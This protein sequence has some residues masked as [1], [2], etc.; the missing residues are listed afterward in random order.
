MSQSVSKEISILAFYVITP[1]SDPHREVKRLKKFLSDLDAR[2]R[3]YISEEGI[4]AQMSIDS[5]ERQM[6]ID[7]FLDH[8]NYAGTPIKVHSYHEHVFPRLTVKYREQIVAFDRSVNFQ[9]KGE[10]VKPQ[11]WKE[12]L[13]ENSPDTVVLDVRNDYEFE[14]GH[15]E[16]SINSNCKTFRE[17]T[18]FAE[19]LKE[20]VDPSK[21]KVMMFCTGGIRCELFSPYLK[22]QGFDTVYQLEGGV[23]QYGLDEGSEKWEG[24]L[25]VFDDRLVVPLK[26]GEKIK[27]IGCC[28]QCEAK[29]SSF[30][31]CANMDCNKL[32]LSCLECLKTLTGCCTTEC[33][34]EGR[35]RPFDPSARPKPFSRLSAEEKTLLCAKTS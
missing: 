22:E 29:T 9:E 5:S 15:F 4:N 31:N 10:Y 11:Q 33:G 28:H 2:S 24:G 7:W 1:I 21:T 6:F 20:R 34:N 13:E 12:M 14:V 8:A 17:F 25:F 3:I 26:E 23:V 35:L 16:N 32:F 19:R 27:D 30:Y 18:Q